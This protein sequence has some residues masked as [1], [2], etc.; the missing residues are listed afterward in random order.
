MSL[1][2]SPLKLICCGSLFS[3]MLKTMAKWVVQQRKTI[4]VRKGVMS[5]VR[6]VSL[7]NT[8]CVGVFLNS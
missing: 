6:S 7:P 8:N 4:E 1:G 2:T 3:K 5:L